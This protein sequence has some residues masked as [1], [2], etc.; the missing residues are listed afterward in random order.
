MF[1]KDK[2][3]LLSLGTI[4]ICSVIVIFGLFVMRQNISDGNPIYDRGALFAVTFG[5]SLLPVTFYNMSKPKTGIV[6]D[7]R[8]K[9]IAEKAGLYALIILMG[10]ILVL[11]LINS[12][13]QLNVNFSLM[14]FVL[15]LIGIYSWSILIYY[16][17]RTG[18]V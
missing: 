6:A 11:S 7:E 1:R 12:L 5:L 13:L 10:C 2:G 14:G 4:G 8:T 15:P 17:G 16:L 9:R 18:D 3:Y